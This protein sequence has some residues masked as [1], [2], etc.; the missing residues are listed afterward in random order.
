MPRTNLTPDAHSGLAASAADNLG[1]T[2]EMRQRAGITKI[3]REVF[4]QICDNI[5]SGLLVVEGLDDDLAYSRAVALLMKDFEAADGDIHALVLVAT[6]C[7]TRARVLILTEKEIE[8]NY[9]MEQ[10]VKAKLAQERVNKRRR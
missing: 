8:C 1:C 9:E 6:Y 3:P 2:E 10:E 7:I 4:V 5:E